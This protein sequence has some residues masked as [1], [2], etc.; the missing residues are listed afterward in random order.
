MAV[1]LTKQST[2]GRIWVDGIIN[3]TETF[4]SFGHIL[5]TLRNEKGI[6]IKKLASDLGVDYTYI[7]KLENAKV[8]PSPHVVKKFSSYFH[9]NSDE[10]LLSAGRLPADIQKILQNDPKGAIEYL[11]NKYGK[12]SRNK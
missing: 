10:L 3:H 4:M 9:Y 12:P 2:D 6:S 8:S 1:G 7:S 11:R 5:K